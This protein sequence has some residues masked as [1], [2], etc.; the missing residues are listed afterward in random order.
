M[1]LTRTSRSLFDY[2]FEFVLRVRCIFSRKM[3]DFYE[4]N[5][6]HK[7]SPAQWKHWWVLS[8][9]NRSTDSWQTRFK[10]VLRYKDKSLTQSHGQGTYVSIV[11]LHYTLLGTSLLT[12]FMHVC[13]QPHLAHMPLELNVKH[14]LVFYDATIRMHNVAVKEFHGEIMSDDWRGL[15]LYYI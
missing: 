15:V 8:M 14:F 10:W 12:N 3:C 4:I 2:N 5:T 9:Q 13:K 6:V 7:Q 1:S 11:D